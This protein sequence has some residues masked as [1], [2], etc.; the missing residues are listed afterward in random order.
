MAFIRQ[1]NN[2]IHMLQNGRLIPVTQETPLPIQIASGQEI[3]SNPVQVDVGNPFQVLPVSQLNTL[4]DGKVLNRLFTELNEIA[5][6]GTPTHQTNKIN[7]AVTSGQWL[8]HSAKRFSPYFSG[9]PQKIELTFDKFAPEANVTKRVGYFSSN[10][11][12]PFASTY[13]GFWLESGNDT[14]KLVV[15]RAGT[16][17]YD[18]D[19][20]SW[21][22]YDNLGDYQSL[23]TWD[24]FT[25]IE[26]NFLWLG[27][28]YLELRLV[29]NTGFI[30]A[31]KLIYAGTAQDV[32]IQSPNQTVRYEIRSTTGS[33]NFRYI[34]NQVATS[35]SIDESFITKSVNTGATSINLATATTK[36][37]LLAV[38]KNASYRQ[39]PV[40]L[41][42][43][44]VFV[45]TISDNILWSLEINP[46]LSAPLT[47]NSVSNSAIQYAVGNGTITTT[48]AGIVISS[49]FLSSGQ[50][51]NPGVFNRNY[52]SWL[53]SA[54]D[55]TPDSYVLSI[56]PIS[57]NVNL[58]AA[59]T[60]GEG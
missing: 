37:P 46:T 53:S 56:T 1:I 36:Y 60:L 10:T 17:V 27:G 5:G 8:V 35:G 58:H 23:A 42:D 54:L 12:T 7:L 55:G 15:S 57:A 20:T 49:G 24:N 39:N 41:I 45:T 13:D 32:F 52:L 22:N 11:T 38:R 25:V 29:T 51:L 26:F 34:C 59:M 43:V 50:K 18:V 40:L 16:T 4:R 30:T 47:Y 6:T 9:K 48:G 2:V 33:G 3:G 31:H 28:A 14:I 21:L 19:I 44:D